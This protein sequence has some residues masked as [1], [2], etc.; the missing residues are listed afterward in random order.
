MSKF[1]EYTQARKAATRKVLRKEFTSFFVAMTTSTGPNWPDI[2]ESEFVD[3]VADALFDM[4]TKR[5]KGIAY[6]QTLV[7]ELQ[8]RIN[9]KVLN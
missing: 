8:D 9:N 1:D 7:H 3:A 6:T 4:A 5:G 2:P